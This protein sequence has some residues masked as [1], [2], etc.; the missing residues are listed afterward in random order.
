MM[1]ESLSK[2]MKNLIQR[3]SEVEAMCRKIH[4]DRNEM[5]EKEKLRISGI[6]REAG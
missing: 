5:V 2:I 3:L 1:I 4:V 6:E